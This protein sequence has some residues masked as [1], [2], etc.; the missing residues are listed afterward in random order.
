[1]THASQDA[2]KLSF[3]DALQELEKIVKRLESG[4]Q[5]LEDSIAAY[6]QGIQLKSH[7]E[8]ILKEATLKI[9]K[10]TLSSTGVPHIEDANLG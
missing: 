5:S 7:C 2:P 10:I 1:M 9:E 8:R 6:E 3:E 4:E